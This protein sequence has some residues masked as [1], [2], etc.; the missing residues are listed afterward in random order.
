MGIFKQI[1]LENDLARLKAAI[2]KMSAKN[3]TAAPAAKAQPKTTTKQ[4]PAA[5]SNE[6]ANIAAVRKGTAQLNKTIDTALK[7]NDPQTAHI[8]IVT[9]IQNAASE[10]AG[11]D[12]DRADFIKMEIMNAAFGYMN[13]KYM[14]GSD[15]NYRLANT[16]DF[17]EQIMQKTGSAGAT[18]G[19]DDGTRVRADFSWD[20]DMTNKSKLKEAAS[21]NISMSGENAGEVA[22]LLDIL[23]N[24]GMA[25][26]PHVAMQSAP[27][28]HDMER[29]RAIVDA[30]DEEES[31]CGCGGDT[32]ENQPNEEYEELDELLTMGT[33][34]HAVKEPQDIRVKDSSAFEDYE[35]EPE[36]EYGTEHYM[37]HDLAGGINKKKK[38]YKASQRGDNAMAV[39]S[40]KDT[41]HSRLAKKLK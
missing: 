4:E 21:M 9:E 27:M 2:K 33:D 15:S 25:G 18:P 28:R 34:L 8:K 11:D 6:D 40:F 35:N 38:M 16:L 20:N 13:K 24:A 7:G 31:S 10:L 12:Y 1:I 17:I 37:T 22:G 26:E 14:G 41:L 29:L 39:E 32:Y 23:K 36:E 19:P 3:A 30:P 5:S